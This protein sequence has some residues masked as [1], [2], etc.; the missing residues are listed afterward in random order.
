MHIIAFVTTMMG[1]YC[2]IFT[3]TNIR[4]HVVAFLLYT[5]YCMSLE[6]NNLM[7]NSNENLSEDEIENYL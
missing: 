1:D 5:S 6:D 2:A 7:L 4:S 3:R